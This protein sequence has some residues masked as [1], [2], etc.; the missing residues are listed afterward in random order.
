M[1]LVEVE[2][3]GMLDLPTIPL[4]EPTSYIL[5]PHKGRGVLWLRM[6]RNVSHTSMKSIRMN[7]KA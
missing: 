7:E 6:K 5:F 3:L 4:V 1:S 2:G